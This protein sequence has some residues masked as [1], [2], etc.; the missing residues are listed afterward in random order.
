MGK[1]DHLAIGTTRGEVQIWDAQACR[2]VRTMTGHQYRVGMSVVWDDL[3]ICK[4]RGCLV[5]FSYA[6]LPMCLVWTSEPR[7]SNFRQHQTDEEYCFLV[8]QQLLTDIPIPSTN[9]GE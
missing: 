5:F 3:E 1:G 6:F 9:Y 4:M 8:L 7:T 2:K